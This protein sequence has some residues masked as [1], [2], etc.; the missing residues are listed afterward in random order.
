M[1]DDDDPQPEPAPPKTWAGAMEALTDLFN[2]WG[3]QWTPRLD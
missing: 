3:P 1:R 2:A